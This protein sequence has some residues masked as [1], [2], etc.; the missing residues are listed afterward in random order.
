MDMA[1]KL[2]TF[3]LTRSLALKYMVM[4]P[5]LHLSDPVHGAAVA[6]ARQ[7]LA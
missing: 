3:T 5:I 1:S 4:A 6:D 7:G 2:F